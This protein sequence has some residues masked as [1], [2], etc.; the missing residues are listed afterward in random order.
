MRA[1]LS[2]QG[3]EV[4]ERDFF[5]DPFTE[6]ELKALLGTRPATDLLAWRSPALKALNVEPGSLGR[7]ELLRLM[8]REPRLLRRPLVQVGET[9]IPGADIKAV[10]EALAETTGTG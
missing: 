1:W 10:E 3:V 6:G 5:R 2:H 8:L 7:E 9:L 4:E